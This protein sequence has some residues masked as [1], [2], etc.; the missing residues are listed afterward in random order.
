[1]TTI[2]EWRWTDELTS[3][4]D[5]ERGTSETHHGREDVGEGARELEHDDDDRDRDAR[6]AAA[7][8]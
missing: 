2:C 6:D 8:M 4:V 3:R 1:M 7:R 5:R